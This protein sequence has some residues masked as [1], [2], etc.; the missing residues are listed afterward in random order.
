MLPRNM[1]LVIVAAEG[2]LDNASAA[3]FIYSSHH[4]SQEYSPALWIEQL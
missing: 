2:R 1:E 3:S 4:E